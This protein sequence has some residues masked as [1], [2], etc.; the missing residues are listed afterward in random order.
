MKRLTEHFERDA[1]GTW[2]CIEPATLNLPSGRV[3]VAPGSV[4]APGAK[5]MNVD[6][7]ALLDEEY[8]KEQGGR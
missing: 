1:S 8:K 5:F 7:A 6:I 2:R 4:F 3:Q